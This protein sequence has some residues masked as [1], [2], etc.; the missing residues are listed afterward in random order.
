MLDFFML[1]PLVLNYLLGDYEIGFLLLNKVRFELMS[2]WA[3]R[4]IDRA[5]V[6]LLIFKWDC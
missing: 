4:E 5:V 3:W 2:A 1:G 6:L